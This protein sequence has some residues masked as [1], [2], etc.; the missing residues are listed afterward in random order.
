MQILDDST[1]VLQLSNYIFAGTARYIA[2][3]KCTTA[4]RGALSASYSSRT[5]TTSPSRDAIQ[6][7]RENHVIELKFHN[8]G[9][10][11][12]LAHFEVQVQKLM[13]WNINLITRL[14]NNPGDGPGRRLPELDIP[15]RE[16]HPEGIDV[17]RRGRPALAAVPVGGERLPHETGGC[18]R[19]EV[20]KVSSG[21][22]QNRI[23]KS[24]ERDS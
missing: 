10:C 15:A 22:L 5:P 4:K 17:H 13:P 9:L 12:K 2:A 18:S 11:D 8:S 6:R 16:R 1:K 19:W 7:R 21:P 14:N 20:G 23:K 24:P 3:T